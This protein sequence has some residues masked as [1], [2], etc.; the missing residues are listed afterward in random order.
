MSRLGFP[1]LFINLCRDVYTDS[2]SS[3][4]TSTGSS[5]PAL[6]F[7]GIKQGCP[8]SPILFNI[9]LQGLLGGLDKLKAGY[10]WSSPT[11]PVIRYL[12]YADDLCFFGHT[13]EDINSLN[14][15]FDSFLNWTGLQLKLSKCRSLSC[16]N[17]AA[18]VYVQSFSPRI[19]GSSIRALKWG[20]RYQYLGVDTGRTCLHSLSEI[21]KS[22]LSDAKSICASLLTDWQKIDAI[23]CFV[24][25]QATYHLHAALPS[26]GWA[27]N[28]DTAIRSSVQKGLH[29]PRRTISSLFYCSQAQGGF[30][31]FSVLDNLHFARI[32]HSLKCIHNKEP[33][34]FEDMKLCKGIVKD[35]L[36]DI[37]D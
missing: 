3:I 23:N 35:Y 26:I 5:D 1:L 17:S 22:M 14:S 31:L 34:S 11:T 13:K 29:L 4:R 15:V 10:S 33:A 9:A 28:L 19:A 20:E 21:E 8:L 7:S 36:K 18:R 24:I 12:A 30:G 6:L 27:R 32:T 25:S 2:T 37:I 16:I